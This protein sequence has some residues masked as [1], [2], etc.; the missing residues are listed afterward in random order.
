MGRDG[1]DEM[2]R[3]DALKSA[4]VASLGTAVSSLAVGQ[5]QKEQPEEERKRAVLKIRESVLRYLAA[6]NERDTK[7]RLELV[8]Q[9]WTEDGTYVDHA[10]QGHDH[11]SISA[12]IAKAQIPLPGYRTY[13]AS[14]IER[15][16]E[17]LRFSWA[18]GGAPETPLYLKGTDIVVIAADFRFKSVIG[19]VD[20]APESGPR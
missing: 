2:N 19:F 5:E 4:L 1:G 16:H 8:S 11:E 3:R 12:M 17:Y 6:W 20:V 9:T 7:R 15:H 14:G 18:A 13:L 10:R